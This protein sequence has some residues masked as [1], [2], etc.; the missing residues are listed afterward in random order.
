MS[1]AG[2][3]KQFD[4]KDLV[5][6]LAGLMGSDT[7]TI[8]LHS[9]LLGLGIPRE[10]LDYFTDCLVEEI[11]EKARYRLIVPVFTFDREPVWSPASSRSHCGALSECFLKKYSAYR[12]VHPIHSV[13]D[14]S[15]DNFSSFAGSISKTSFGADTVWEGVLKDHRTLNVGIGIGLDGGGTFLHAIEQR[16]NITYREFITLG[17]TVEIDGQTIDNFEY[18]AR[19]S[20]DASQ[21]V[22][23]WEKVRLD[24]LEKGLYREI[25]DPFFISLSKP[26]DVYP[27]LK[28]KLE[29][30]PEWFVAR[31]QI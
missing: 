30:D 26:A 28:S 22:H 25:E 12:T 18:F 6:V 29:L 2:I 24:L 11:V 17:K 8:V 21:T 14:I 7:D 19:V 3:L 1:Q 13:L 20:S 4:S 9:S 23:D 5:G 16:A 27:Y 15:S 10:G 31:E